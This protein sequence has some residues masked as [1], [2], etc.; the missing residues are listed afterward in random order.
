MFPIFKLFT[1]MILG[2]A[3]LYVIVLTY[4]PRYIHLMRP[5][6]D[7]KEGLENNSSDSTPA[8]L[9]PLVR[10]NADIHADSLLVS[11]YRPNYE[12]ILVDLEGAI[13][14]A[15]LKHISDNSKVISDNPSSIASIRRMDE[16]NTMSKFI[17]TINS[18][19]AVLD[20]S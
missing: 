2:Y 6:M 16:I 14:N 3:L 5:W 18:A 9:A 17:E 15:M 12:S 20:K 10:V 13:E 7:V 8:A 11:T 4:M 1:C 19:M